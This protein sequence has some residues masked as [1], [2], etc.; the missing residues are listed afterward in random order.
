MSP[1]SSFLNFSD[2][3]FRS[4]PPLI[5]L[6]LRAMCRR[7]HHKTLHETAFHHPFRSIGCGNRLVGQIAKCQAVV[8][9]ENT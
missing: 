7:H 1:P 4:T 3:P 2:S 9:L 8:N 6:T 5:S